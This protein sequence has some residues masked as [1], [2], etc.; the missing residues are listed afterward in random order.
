MTRAEGGRAVDSA[1]WTA[2]AADG[3]E[4]PSISSFCKQLGGFQTLAYIQKVSTFR[5]VLR[6]RRAEQMFGKLQSTMQSRLQKDASERS[7]Y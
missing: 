2:R 1:Q 5:S 7:R 6:L 4:L 3:A